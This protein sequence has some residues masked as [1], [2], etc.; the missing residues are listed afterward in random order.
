MNVTTIGA[1]T[2]SS[3]AEDSRKHNELGKNDFLRLLTIQLKY[4]DPMDPVKDHDFIAQLAQ[5]SALEQTEN[6]SQV[7]ERF[8]ASQEKMG[9]VA[10]ATGLLGKEVVVINSATQETATGIVSSIRFADGVPQLQVNGE[11]YFLWEVQSINT[12]D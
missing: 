3:R 5:F 9:I 12:A 2:Y 1:S 8:V 4:Q 11:T 10:Q 6:L 7:M